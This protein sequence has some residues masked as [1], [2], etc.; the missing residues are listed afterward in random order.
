M[1]VSAALIV[2][3][4]C[5][6]NLLPDVLT[7]EQAI[8]AATDGTHVTVVGTVHTVSWDSMQ[9]IAR[10]MQL[11]THEEDVEWVLEQDAEEARGVHTAF[12]DAG[13]SYPRSNDFYILIRSET[14]DG[15]VQTEPGFSPSN[16][17][18]AWGLGVHL[19]SIDPAR[20][21]PDV[22]ATIRVS[23]TFQRVQW[24][25]REIELPIIEG[26]TIQVITGASDLAGPGDPCELD[27]ACNA[28][29]V[30]DRATHTC[31]SPPREIYWADPWRDGNGACDID[32]DCPL[33]QVCDAS[34]VI[35]GSGAFAAHYFMTEDI[36]RHQCVL[37]P[38]MATVAAQCPHVYTTRDLAGG[39]F[40]TGKEVCVR[41]N[42]LQAVPA[43]D[44]DTHDQMRVDEPIPYPGADIA[45]NL[46][47][48]TTENGP[49]YKDP[50]LPGG[51]VSDPAVD[52]EVIAVGTYRYDPDHG[53]YEVH[54]VKAYLA[55]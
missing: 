45:Y 20:P 41:A 26:P 23:G 29:L 27:Q 39:R 31:A 8:G 50:T 12:D 53:W 11:T 21:L 46:F 2:L 32:D 34:H 49:I 13:A 30:C 48:A 43:E 47:G 28:R 42:L 17:A 19:T 44:G 18:A 40:V 6:D 5:G 52:Q 37:A 24:N 51:A 33:G 15:I 10:R 7:P 14:P 22:G 1:R 55:P 16:L 3:A 54:P 35:A 9:S 36:G 38:G 4:G 25:Q